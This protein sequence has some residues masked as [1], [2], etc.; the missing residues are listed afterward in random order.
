MPSKF[1][2][3]FVECECGQEKQILHAIPGEAGDGLRLRVGNCSACE[4]TKVNEAEQKMIER[5]TKAAGIFE[6]EGK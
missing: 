2:K 1:Y 3:V 4:Y 5:F 6:K